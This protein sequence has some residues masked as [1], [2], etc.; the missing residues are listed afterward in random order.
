MSR[1]PE[2]SVF[3][4]EDLRW[5]DR[6]L[7]LKELV[8]VDKDLT[9]AN[10][11]LGFEWRE[12]NTGGGDALGSLPF[13]SPSVVIPSSEAVKREVERLHRLPMSGL[14]GEPAG[15]ASR[16]DSHPSLAE[17]DFDELAHL[18]KTTIGPA[19]RPLK[20][21]LRYASLIKLA[22]VLRPRH[23]KE[24]LRSQLRAVQ[25]PGQQTPQTRRRL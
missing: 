2:V 17:S 4:R 9:F 16:A 3:H 10:L 23:E 22:D 11:D 19:H 21:V 24:S 12:R 7:E 25:A 6:L 18:W 5:E 1:L 20:A 15:R 8:T 13:E 14:S